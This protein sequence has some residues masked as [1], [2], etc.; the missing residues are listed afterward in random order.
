MTLSGDTKLIDGYNAV[1]RLCHAYLTGLILSTVLRRSRTDAAELVFRTFRRQHLEKFLPGLKKL[2]LTGLPDAVACAQYH[3]LSNHL[4]GVRVEYIYE[5]DR[6]AWVRY[7]PPRWIYDGTAICGMPTEVS[8]AMM[9]GWHAHNGVSL[10]NPR[11][12][13]ICTKQTTDGQ[14]GLEGYYLEYHRDISPEER[15]RFEP[16]EEGPDFDPDSAPRVEGADWPH[17]RMQKILRNYA[18]AYVRTILPELSRLFGPGD[19]GAL[20]RITGKLIGMQYYYETAQLLDV[21]GVTAIDFAEYMVRM[22]R[23]QGDE[24]DYQNNGSNVMVRQNGWR[25]MQGLWPL[26]PAVFD[27]WNGLF[28]GAISVHNRHLRLEVTS[29]M[30]LGDDCFM[31]RIKEQTIGKSF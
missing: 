17:D 23:A 12:G 29:R 25:L 30:D 13:F 26:S 27:S 9:L 15:L 31:W 28:E 24:I 4:G 5:N 18:M 20:G 16:G 2:G 10:K 8:R 19:G 22:G 11:L 14:P 6:K 1:Y 21:R 3:Y 7:V